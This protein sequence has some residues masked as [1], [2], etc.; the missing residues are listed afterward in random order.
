MIEVEITCHTERLADV[1]ARL[2][3]TWRVTPGDE[4]SVLR[5][6]LP[7]DV[8]HQAQPIAH[9]MGRE[10]LV[11]RIRAGNGNMGTERAPGEGYPL[12]TLPAGESRVVA[13]YR[14]FGTPRKTDP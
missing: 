1:L 7:D 14:F 2:P 9:Q 8:W 10:R 13:S 12:S 4:L 3:G 5:A 11:T 6:R